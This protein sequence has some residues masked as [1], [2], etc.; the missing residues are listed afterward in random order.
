MDENDLVTRLPDDFI[1][2]KPLIEAARY[3]QNVLQIEE[4]LGG[5]L[6]P[7]DKFSLVI[8]S[9]V[10]PYGGTKNTLPDDVCEFIDK[11]RTIRD[12]KW[13]TPGSVGSATIHA[14]C[15][16]NVPREEG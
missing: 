9:Y 14:P 13:K 4:C 10:N 3:L 8:L 7:S 5:S 12:L 15:P 16:E 1:R 6:S 2:A 11:V